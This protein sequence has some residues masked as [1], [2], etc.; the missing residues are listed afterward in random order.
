MRKFRKTS[1]VILILLF[2]AA[3]SNEGKSKIDYPQAIECTSFE[4]FLTALKTVTPGS[5]LK[6]KYSFI[7]IG[8]LEGN[9]Y[10]IR[11]ALFETKKNIVLDLSDAK[12]I[13][14]IPEDAFYISGKNLVPLEGFVFPKTGVDRIGNNAFAYCRSLSNLLIPNSVKEIGEM[15][16]YNC[17]GLINITLPDEIESIEKGVFA[18]CGGLTNLIVPDSV[19]KIGSGSFGFCSNLINIDIPFGVEIIG[20]LAFVDCKNLI[21]ITIPDSIVKID[22]N[23]F[24]GCVGLTYINIPKNV[25][26][27]GT[28]VFFNCSNLNYINV[29]PENAIYTTI[30]GSL[31]SKNKKILIQYAP[32]KKG[33]CVI[34]KD[35][36]IIGEYA[37]ASCTNLT[38]VLIPERVANIKEFAFHN[39]KC[40]LSIIFL[41]NTPPVLNQDV[42]SDNAVDRTITVPAG[43]GDVYR[44]AKGWSQYAS[45]IKAVDEN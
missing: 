38:I 9:F 6:L 4:E 30:E 11:D 32:G 1:Y 20:Q 2:I 37:F 41:G 16:F 40:L 34:P 5:T 44:T 10:Q 43:T 26:T 8:S 19:K 22:D 23:S 36:E 27:I 25:I 33:S 29:N 13:T 35:V 12:D 17:S 3:F 21:N 31:Y 28:S 7:T 39:C 42:F 45:F 18:F 24:F 15:A 14:E